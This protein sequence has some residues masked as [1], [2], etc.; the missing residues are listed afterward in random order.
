M[1]IKIDKNDIKPCNLNNIK[2]AGK[3]FKA[4]YTDGDL[5]NAYQRQTDDITNFGE[6]LRAT[7]E[8]FEYSFDGS[9]GFMVELLTWNGLQFHKIKFFVDALLNVTVDNPLLITVDRYSRA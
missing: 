8:V 7:V 5:L 3:E 2:A 4:A 9:A 6:V 1:K